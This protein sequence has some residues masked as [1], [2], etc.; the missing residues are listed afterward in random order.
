VK[1]NRGIADTDILNAT[2]ASWAYN[3]AKFYLKEVPKLKNTHH[4]IL[5]KL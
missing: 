3:P 4:N 5:I 2:A 1:L